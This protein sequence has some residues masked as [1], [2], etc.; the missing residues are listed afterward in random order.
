MNIHANLEYISDATGEP[1]TIAV[2]VI[3]TETA[4]NGVATAYQVRKEDGSVMWVSPSS[5]V[6]MWDRR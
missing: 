6:H 5:V 1:Y 2:E 4:D 3:D